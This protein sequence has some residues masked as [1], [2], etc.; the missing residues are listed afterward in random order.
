MGNFPSAPRQRPQA[1]YALREGMEE[2]IRNLARSIRIEAE[3]NTRLI[4]QKY[5]RREQRYG[6][7]ARSRRHAAGRDRSTSDDGMRGHRHFTAPEPGQFEPQDM[8]YP[9]S[10]HPRGRSGNRRGTPKGFHSR[11]TPGREEPGLDENNLENNYNERM[12]EQYPDFDRPGPIPPQ[13]GGQ[14]HSPG[15]R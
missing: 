10:P 12:C 2:E 1:A 13:Q 15:R 4:Q 5:E 3:N 6:A 14:Q 11:Y 7:G 9:G 8:G